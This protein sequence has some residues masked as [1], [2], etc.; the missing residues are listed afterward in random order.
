[1][2]EFIRQVQDIRKEMELAYDARIFVEVYTTDTY[3]AGVIA[4]YNNTIKGETLAESIT[5]GEPG[6]DAKDCE[7]EGSALRL[8]VTVKA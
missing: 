3:L 4:Q 7:I 5:L 1:M 2:R 6:G 8:R